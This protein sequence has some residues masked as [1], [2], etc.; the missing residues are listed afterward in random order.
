M[1]K[2]ISIFF[3][4]ILIASCNQKQS[5]N[6]SYEVADMAEEM[7]PMEIPV[8]NPFWSLT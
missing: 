1:K 3:L 2:I 6:A 7:L 8:T 5:E 4:A